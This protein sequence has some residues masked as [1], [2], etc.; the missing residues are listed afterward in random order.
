MVRHRADRLTSAGQIAVIC[1][2]CWPSGKKIRMSAGVSSPSRRMTN[3]SIV[4][5]RR[6]GIPSNAQGR[7]TGVLG[8]PGVFLPVLGGGGEE[9]VAGGG[10]FAGEACSHGSAGAVE[11]GGVVEEVVVPVG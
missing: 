7:L 3:A 4:S 6:T 8:L 11:V 2:C 1:P 9:G 5:A 10:V